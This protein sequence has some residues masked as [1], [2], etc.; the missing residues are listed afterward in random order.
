MSHKT[1][2]DSHHLARFV[3]RK[4]CR[5]DGDGTVIG[6]NYTA[7][8]LRKSERYLSCNCIELAAP[9]LLDGIKKIS[10]QLS[11]KLTTTKGALTIG[12]VALIKNA[13]EPHK[14]RITLNPTTSDSSY[15]AV[16]KMPLEDVTALERLASEDWAAWLR[17]SDV[18]DP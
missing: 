1:A 2:P 12:R 9:T 6:V 16:R 11:K 13:F 14:V 7:F 5:T 17:I 3:K 4:H 8:E 15:S 18:P 10:K